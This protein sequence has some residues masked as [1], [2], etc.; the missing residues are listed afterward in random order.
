VDGRARDKALRLDAQKKTLGATERDEQAR[1]A[2]RIQVASYNQDQVVVVD[3]CGSNINLTPIYARA[4]KGERAVD[5]VPRNTAQNTTLIAS[6]TTQGMGAAML[7]DGAT[8]G[9]AFESYVAHFLAPTLIPGQIVV[10]D[11]LR[12]HKRSG[13]HEL[14]EARGCTVLYLPAYSPDLSPIEEA[15]STLKALVRRVRARTREA[16]YEAI[17]T[18]LEQ[19]TAADAQGY[20]AHCGYGIAVQ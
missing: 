5:Q 9:I 4:P 11:N 16:L 17:A 6:M 12:A 14:I 13:V 3:E 2:Y 19:I 7:L 18:A 20:F 15:F 10:M 1:A 8:D